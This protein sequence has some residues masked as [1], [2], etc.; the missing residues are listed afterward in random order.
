ME[1]IHDYIT[2]YIFFKVGQRV[3]VN[4]IKLKSLDGI[5][6][7]N[8]VVS[9]PGESN[10]HKSYVYEIDATLCYDKGLLPTY[11]CPPGFNLVRD[12]CRQIRYG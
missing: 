8:G 6:S 10:N 5:Q 7:T 4:R 11:T 3:E 9:F 2:N 1:L 12:K